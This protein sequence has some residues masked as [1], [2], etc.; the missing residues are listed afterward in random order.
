MIKLIASDM[1]GTLI[2]SNHEVSSET[3][4]AIKAAQAKGIE[5]IITTGR[6]FEDARSQVD[7]A[8]I[9]CNYLVMNG[10]ELR[11]SNGN[12]LQQLYLD[13]EIV[14]KIVDDLLQLDLCVE[15]Y[16]TNGTYTLGSLESCK[17]AVA[18]KINNFY[19]EKSVETYYQTAEEHFL[20][21]ELNRISDLSE[22]FE[23]KYQVGKIICFSPKV[24][25]IAFLR[26]DIKQRY[27]VNSTGSFPINLEVTN[28]LANKGAALARYAESK[29]IDITDVMT[30]GDSFN[31]MTM[32]DAP[33]GYTVAMGNAIEPIKD[34]AKYLTD[35]N[36][37]DGVGK[38]INRLINNT[39]SEENT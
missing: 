7:E 5:F 20:F 35:S 30:I 19:P 3:I 10:S 22:V 14:Q 11:D 8:G 2:N 9:T 16:S 26:E 21:Q 28:P 24:E 15:V 4:K 33:F 27:N 39:H 18:A 13:Q 32:I 38:I 17:W 23:K 25:T 34:I 12:I 31:D 6:S 29:N 1:D 36:D 37:N